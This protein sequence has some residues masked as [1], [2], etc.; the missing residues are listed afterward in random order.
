MQ[1]RQHYA[2]QIL[3]FMQDYFVDVYQPYSY[4]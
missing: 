4:S 3:N 1:L 2:K